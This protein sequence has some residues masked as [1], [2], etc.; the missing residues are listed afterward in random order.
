[1]ATDLEQFMAEAKERDNQAGYVG[2]PM[3]EEDWRAFAA[4]QADV[5]P[6]VLMLRKVRALFANHERCHNMA[7]E[8]RRAACVIDRLAGEAREK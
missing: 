5:E 1:M 7:C 8:V 4:S 3:D 6:L 2:W